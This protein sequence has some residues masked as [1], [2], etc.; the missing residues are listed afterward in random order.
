LALNQRLTI[1]SLQSNVTELAFI[2]SQLVVEFEFDFERTKTRE[3][4]LGVSLKNQKILF[5][6]PKT[7]FLIRVR[8]TICV[9]KLKSRSARAEIDSGWISMKIDRKSQ[10]RSAEVKIKP[11]FR[12][13]VPTADKPTKDRERDG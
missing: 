10:I 9:S 8:V 3:K 1:D 13:A 4:C 7:L 2:C 11:Q 12:H 5:Q 6:R